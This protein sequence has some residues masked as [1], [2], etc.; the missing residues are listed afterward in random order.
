MLRI[1]INGGTA[2]RKDDGHRAVGCLRGLLADLPVNAQSMETFRDRTVDATCNRH[3]VAAARNDGQRSRRVPGLKLH[4]S[5]NNV[6]DTVL[7][8][9]SPGVS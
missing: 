8:S 7:I 3:I 6:R 4:L 9:P 1:V 2:E 5:T